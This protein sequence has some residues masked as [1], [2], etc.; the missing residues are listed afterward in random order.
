LHLLKKI[1]ALPGTQINQKQ[2]RVILLQD[3]GEAIGFRNVPEQRARAQKSAAS[4]NEIV[5]LRVEKT[6]R[7]RD[8]AAATSS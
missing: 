1:A 5:I 8:H 4:P 6:G 3:R 7:V 2:R